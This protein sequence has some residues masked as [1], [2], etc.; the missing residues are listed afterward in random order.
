MVIEV[1]PKLFSR[2]FR[3]LCFIFKGFPG[4]S[5]GKES[6]CNVSWRREWPIHSSILAWRTPSLTEKPGRPHTGLQSSF[7]AVPGKLPEVLRRQLSLAPGLKP[8]AQLLV[9]A[10]QRRQSLLAQHLVSTCGVPGPGEMARILPSWRRRWLLL[11][12]KPVSSHPLL[13]P[14]FVLMVRLPSLHG[15]LF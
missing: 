4:G 12:D 6:A 11:S 10:S 5:D 14:G 15:L 3:V 8:A 13:C 2:S 7:A 9:N 1:Y